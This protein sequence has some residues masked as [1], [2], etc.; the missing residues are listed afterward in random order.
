[1]NRDA[2]DSVQATQQVRAAMHQVTRRQWSLWFTGM[3]VAILAASAIAAFTLPGLSPH[4]HSEWY[5]FDRSLL[6]R[7][8]MCMVSLFGVYV[9]H[10][11]FQIHR[12]DVS[13]SGA[14]GEIQKRTEREHK[15]VGRDD[16]TGL[17]TRKFG[18]QRLFEEMAWSKRNVKPLVILRVNL[19][20]VEKIEER[21]G[22][23]SADSAI[24]LFAE[25]LQHKVR[26]CDVAVYLDRG[27]FLILLPNCKSNNADIVLN[28]L[29]HLRFEFGELYTE[30]SGGWANYVVGETVRELLMRAENALHKQGGNGAT[31]RP[32]VCISLD[33]NGEARERI[34]KLTPRERDVFKLLA[35]GRNNK[36]VAN[37]LGLSFRTVEEYRGNVMS[38]L[39]VH[40][41]PELVFYAARNGILDLE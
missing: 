40:S 27:Q 34:A 25:R 28:R 31:E 23:P 8:L 19:D 36:E 21:V 3:I 38:T 9:I 7:G 20:G 41:G 33:G 18:E 11:Q 1:M 29:N 4:A 35:K 15:L 37:A 30:I 17:Y 39:G 26:S 6:M 13:I 2:R 10:E 14:L 32:Q 5:I 22:S 12:V 24:R 16:L